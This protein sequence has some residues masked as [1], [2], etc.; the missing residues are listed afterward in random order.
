[1]I[2]GHKYILDITICIGV[3]LDGIYVV[4]VLDLR[5]LWSKFQYGCT[6]FPTISKHFEWVL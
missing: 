5:P 2:Q 6:S 1:M 4:R 3:G